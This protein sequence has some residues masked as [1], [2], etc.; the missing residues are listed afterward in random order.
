MKPIRI[1]ITDDHPLMANGI[2]TALSENDEILVKAMATNGKEALDLI[3][4]DL[5]DV[6]LLDIEMP[7]M[8]GIECAKVI[9]DEYPDVRI[10]ILSM[11]QEPSVIKHL[12]EIGVKGYVLKTIPED[13][14]VSAI[15]KV[16]KGESYF[17]SNITKALVSEEEVSK[18]VKIYEKSE[19][20][21]ELTKREIEILKLIAKGHTNVEIA[22]MLFISHR[23]VDTHRTNMLN[24][25]NVNNVAGLVRFAFEN[26]VI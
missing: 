11:H 22:E 12:M 5:F 17:G 23:T 16:H 9:I 20:L 8:N 19:L 10:L 13:D 18:T 3:S 7:E 14:L 24:K 15:K 25:L 26:G 4:E 21:E 1:L 2:A 6:I